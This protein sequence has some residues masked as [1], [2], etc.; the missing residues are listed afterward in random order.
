EEGQSSDAAERPAGACPTGSACSVEV[1]GSCEDVPGVVVDVAGFGCGCQITDPDPA[2][3]TCGGG[4][5]GTCGAP[6]EYQVSAF[7]ARGTCLPFDYES[8][9]CACYAIGAGAQQAVEGCGGVLAAPC[10]EASSGCCA[11][12]PRGACDPQNGLVACP[13]I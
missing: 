1:L 5:S 13:G 12:D 10:P 9:E 6:C 2:C 3:I 4:A 11:T 7:T 8:E